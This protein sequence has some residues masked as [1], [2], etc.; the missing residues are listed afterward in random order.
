[1]CKHVAAVLY[2]VGARLDEH[3][4]LLF[5]LRG[6]DQSRLVDHAVASDVTSGAGTQD[7]V[8][9]GDADLKDV[10]GI[11]L[12]SAPP[13][14][15]TARRAAVAKKKAAPRK[16]PAAR[17]KRPSKGKATATPSAPEPEPEKKKRGRPK[18]SKDKR[19][20]L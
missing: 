3:P 14:P 10:F 13:K 5:T 4:E 6:A 20:R 8:T 17:K 7:A 19:R 15:V 12:D 11:E 1:M 9:L 16:Q 2:G 18:G